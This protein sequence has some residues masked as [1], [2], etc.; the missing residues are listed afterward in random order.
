MKEKKPLVS[1]FLLPSSVS[2]GSTSFFVLL[3][4]RGRK[5]IQAL[6]IVGATIVDE[7]LFPFRGGPARQGLPIL[8]KFHQRHAIAARGVDEMNRGQDNLSGPG[9]AWEM[10]HQFLPAVCS[11]QN[12]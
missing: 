9:I 8:L 3:C 11:W 6:A 1:A 5:V 10:G 4:Q 7:P 12:G 2:P